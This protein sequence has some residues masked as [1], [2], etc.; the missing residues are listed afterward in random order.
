MTSSN[1]QGTFWVID[2][3]RIKKKRPFAVTEIQ[4]IF[5]P[6]H[7]KEEKEEIVEENGHNRINM[8]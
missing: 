5:Q 6:S 7:Y 2:G 4:R 1:R 8:G 3:L